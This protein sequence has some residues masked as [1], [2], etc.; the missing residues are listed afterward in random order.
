[1]NLSTK[2]SSTSFAGTCIFKMCASLLCKWISRHPTRLAHHRRTSALSATQWALLRPASPTRLRFCYRNPTGQ[3][4][5]KIGA[6]GRA[7]KSGVPGPL[8]SSLVDHTRKQHGNTA[9][10]HLNSQ[11]PALSSTRA[12]QVSIACRYALSLLQYPLVEI[13]H[14]SRLS[15]Y[16]PSTG[17]HM[18]STIDRSC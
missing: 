6:L 11:L 5:R 15:M 12:H 2:A 9:I 17:S 13:P 10:A 7:A 3:S 14:S 16:P 8:G 18:R 4:S 1:V